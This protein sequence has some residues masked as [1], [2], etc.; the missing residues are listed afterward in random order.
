MQRRSFLRA[1][2]GVP[3]LPAALSALPAR[4]PKYLDSAYFPGEDVSFIPI[5]Q[6][7]IMGRIRITQE[8]M[9]DCGGGAFIQAT[10]DEFSALLHDMA[11][12]A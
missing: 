2:A 10:R 1:L 6:R 7:K 4:C 12:L 8:L 9:E 3:F 11:A 5:S